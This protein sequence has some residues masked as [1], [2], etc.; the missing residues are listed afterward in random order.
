MI[1]LSILDRC[2]ANNYEFQY[3]RDCVNIWHQRCNLLWLFCVDMPV[4]IIWFIPLL[5]ESNYNS[6]F[7]LERAKRRELEVTSQVV[8]SRTI[9]NFRISHKRVE[10]MGYEDQAEMYLEALGN[11]TFC[12]HL[13]TGAIRIKCLN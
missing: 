8:W 3:K 5:K 4:F 11:A 9:L 7:I 2:A 1:S 10:I 13:I 6:H 12:L